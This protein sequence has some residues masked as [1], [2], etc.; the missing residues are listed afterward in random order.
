MP[1]DHPTAK[2][3]RSEELAE[4][5]GFVPAIPAPI[6]DLGLI[7]SPQSTKSTQS[8]SIRYKTRTAQS[9]GPHTSN[10]DTSTN[11]TSLP[12]VVVSPADHANGYDLR[13][14]RLVPCG[15]RGSVTPSRTPNRD[16]TQAT[17][18]SPGT[19]RI[20]QPAD[21]TPPDSRHPQHF[22]TSED[23]SDANED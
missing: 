5:V 18:T 15:G 13:L 14:I 21:R 8:L 17:G 6:N 2:A 10:A 1:E 7:R 22:A 4:R 20:R 9:L 19:S 11:L 12:S 16:A 3:E 23:R